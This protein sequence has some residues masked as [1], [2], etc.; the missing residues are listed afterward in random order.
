MLILPF[1]LPVV[2]WLWDRIDR[3]SQGQ[4]T[5]EYAL[6][7]LGAASIALLLVAWAARSGRVGD[8]LDS[9][10]NTIARKAR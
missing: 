2:Q 3:R 10:F 8:L 1:T 5:A 4:A 6:V 9:V 7:I